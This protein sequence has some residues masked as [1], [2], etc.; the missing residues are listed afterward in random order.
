MRYER[1][2]DFTLPDVNN[3]QPKDSHEEMYGEVLE[4]L[5][6]LDLSGELEGCGGL[7][8]LLPPKTPIS[9]IKSANL[10]V[11]FCE[12]CPTHLSQDVL[13]SLQP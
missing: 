2:W 4:Q 8:T 12:S 3:S 6:K 9:D 13:S 1:L 5:E 7:T 11:E 10:I